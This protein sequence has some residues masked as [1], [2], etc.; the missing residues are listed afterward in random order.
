MLVRLRRLRTNPIIREMVA[1]TRLSVDMLV[2]PYF[3]VA[4][5]NVK[6]PITAMPGIN[7]FSVDTLISDVAEGLKIGINKILLFGVGEQK[8]EDASS[9]YSAQ[10]IVVH[11]VR[12][13]KSAFGD[14]I[15]IITDGF[16]PL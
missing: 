4:G 2:Y 7:H 15:F 14:K 16:K 13:L 11:A 5:Q 9:S 12:D 6:S 8:T 1:E 3:V 10:S